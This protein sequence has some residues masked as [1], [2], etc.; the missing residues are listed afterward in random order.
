LGKEE[1]M[2]KQK[3]RLT[4]EKE[5]LLVPL[6][7]KAVESQRIHPLIIDPKAV[8][9]LDNI[10]YD[11]RELNVPKQTLVTLAMR[12]KK[13]D[14]YVR[15]YVNRT[16]KPL[17]LH[18]GCGLDSRILRVRPTKGEWYDLDYPDVIELRK[19]FY[20]ETDNYHMIPSSVTDPTW[21]DQVKGKSPACIIAEGLLMYLHENEVK[22]LFGQLRERMPMSEIS[23]DAYSRLTAKGANNHPSI[24]KTGAKI[25]WGI[26]NAKQ[27]ETW[28]SGIQLIEEWYFTDSEDIRVL[29]FWDRSLFRIMGVFPA[30]KKAHRILH[31]RL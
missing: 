9:I 26:D 4:Q 15:D 13:L 27:I 21:L 19:K 29:G 10:E 11:F 6:Y 30:A 25:Y 18:L 22:Q 16:E 7:S 23:F 1:N 2:V 5:T 12:A 20:E 28:G 17:V 8:E 3:I 24:K 31:F 14:T